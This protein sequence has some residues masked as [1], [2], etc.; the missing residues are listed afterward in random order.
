MNL[1]TCALLTSLSV[2]VSACGVASQGQTAV[3][4]QI[5]S[6][7]AGRGG[8][9]T[10]TFNT[11]PLLS[12]VCTGVPPNCSIFDDIGSVTMNVI[13]KDPGTPTA[14]NA[15]S[16][17]N[18]V[19]FTRY[20]VA[21]RRADGRNTPGVDVPFPFDSAVTFTAGP[22]GGGTAQFEIVRHDAKAEAPLKALSSDPVVVTTI[23]DVTFYGKDG[24]GKSVAVTGS[25]Q[26]N[27]ANFAD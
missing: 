10:T 15:P 18:S 21:Y 20:H 5:T 11:G 23:A 14:T 8:S 27:F 25:I 17:L 3:L 6:L 9:T 22:S 16:D 4:V 2:L 26:V 7:Q 13:L 12:D 24:A 1:K 19:T